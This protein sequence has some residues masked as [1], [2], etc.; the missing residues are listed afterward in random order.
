VIYTSGSTGVPKGVEITHRSLLNLVEWHQSAFEIT[1]SDRATQLASIGFDAAVWELWPHLAAGASVYIADEKTRTSPERLRDWLVSCGITVSFVPTPLAERLMILPWPAQ[2]TLRIMLTGGDR[3]HRYP[4]PDVPFLLVNNYGPTECTVVATSGV[5]LPK[6][7]ANSMPPIGSAITNTEILILDSQMRP[8]PLGEIGEIYIGGLSLA[9][10]YHNRP[11]LTAESFLRYPFGTVLSDRVYRTGD[12]GRRL[13]DGQ[14]SFEGRRDE[15]IK[16]RGF[17]VEPEEITTVLSRHPTVQTSVVVGWGQNPAERKLVA[18]VVA[19]PGHEATASELRN[20][21]AKFLPEYMVPSLFVRLDSIPLTV[22][23][24]VDRGALPTLTSSNILREATTLPESTVEKSVAAI[25]S[26]LLKLN[27]IGRDE[28]MFLLGGHSL[29]GMELISEIR[30]TFKV[31]L[32]VPMLFER[33]TIRGLAA[34]IE[35]LT[36]QKQQ[37]L[38]AF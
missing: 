2:T 1:P 33:P 34:K 28:N 14:I 23:G 12:L 11:D 5:V 17:R 37:G 7:S 22:N 27:S 3:L 16:V 35:W 4:P 8:V 19:V 31:E 13:P 10:G 25:L 9:R 29:L 36:L 6:Q 38:A 30:E 15:Q 24:K 32:N 20:H 18:Y 21:V 26:R